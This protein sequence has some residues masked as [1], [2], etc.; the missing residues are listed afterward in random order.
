V[1][2]S[3]EHKEHLIEYGARL[4]HADAQNATSTLQESSKKGA[5]NSHHG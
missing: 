2:L 1:K 5:G 3:P 4:P